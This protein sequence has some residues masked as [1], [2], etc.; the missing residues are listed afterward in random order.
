MTHRCV[1]CTWEYRRTCSSQR[2]SHDSLSILSDYRLSAPDQVDC[3]CGIIMRTPGARLGKECEAVPIKITQVAFLES[4]NLH[5]PFVQPY[6]TRGQGD[7]H[8]KV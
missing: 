3:A 2:V 4:H 6:V 1:E 7:R 5:L 8:G